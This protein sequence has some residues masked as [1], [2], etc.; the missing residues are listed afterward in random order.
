MLLFRVL[1]L[2]Q[3]H[4]RWHIRVLPSLADKLGIHLLVFVGLAVD[5]GF[6]VFTSRLHNRRVPSEVWSATKLADYLLVIAPW[7]ASAAAAAR[8]RLATAPSPS[9]SAFSANAK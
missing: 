9:W 4:N 6:E 1:G 3:R 7:T 2:R 5:R 8:N